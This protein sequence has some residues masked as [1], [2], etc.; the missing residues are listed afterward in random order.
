[1]YARQSDH[2]LT[3]TKKG[4]NF[5]FYKSLNFACQFW[6]IILMLVLLRNSNEIAVNA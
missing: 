4:M 6:K 3:T 2:K 1:M 5:F